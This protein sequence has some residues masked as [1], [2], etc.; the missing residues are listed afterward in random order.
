MSD[1]LIRAL[2]HYVVLDP[3]RGEQI[4]SAAESRSWLAQQLQRLPELPADLAAQG[5]QSQQ[6][7]WLLDTACALELEPGL[8]VQ[9]FAVRLEP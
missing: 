1:P 2:D 5:D 7:E 9:W 4:L 8:T 3:Q 6:V